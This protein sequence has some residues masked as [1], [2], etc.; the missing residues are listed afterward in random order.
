MNSELR[1]I[2]ATIKKMRLALEMSQ[3]DLAGLAELDRSYLSEVENGKKNISFV[4]LHKICQALEVKPSQFL[5]S[6]NL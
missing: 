3:E 2:G 1:K 4:S 6:L 5:K